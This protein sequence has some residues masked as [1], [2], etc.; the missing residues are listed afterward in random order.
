[1]EK[2]VEGRV[3]SMDCAMLMVAV[4]GG[5]FGLAVEVRRIWGLRLCVERWKMVGDEW[6]G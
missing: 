5:A 4:A 3:M 1:M 6:S 2:A